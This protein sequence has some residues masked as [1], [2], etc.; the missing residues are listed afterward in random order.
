MTNLY[1]DMNHNDD[2]RFYPKSTWYNDDEIGDIVDRNV[3]VAAWAIPPGLP[4]YKWIGNSTD[5]EGVRWPEEAIKRYAHS[6]RSENDIIATVW[7]PTKSIRWALWVRENTGNVQELIDWLVLIQEGKTDAA[8]YCDLES[9]RRFVN[10]E[11]VSW[12]CNEYLIGGVPNGVNWANVKQLEAAG[13]HVFALESDSCGW[14]IGGVNIPGKT[15][16]GTDSI[17]SFG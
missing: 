17:L 5:W 12:M 9:H 8:V 4:G 2:Y 10:L 16:G 3:E 14:V 15:P 6:E 13:F 7:S 11:H 1:P